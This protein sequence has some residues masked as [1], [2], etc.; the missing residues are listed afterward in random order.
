[1]EIWPKK[2]ES[3]RGAGFRRMMNVAFLKLVK[4][5]VIAGYPRIGR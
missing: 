2:C 5:E 3:G 4:Y 1:M